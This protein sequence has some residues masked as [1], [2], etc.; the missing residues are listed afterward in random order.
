MKIQ[1]KILLLKSRAADQRACSAIIGAGSVYWRPIGTTDG[2]NRALEQETFQL[3]V[4]DHRNSGSDGTAA[5]ASLRKL[6]PQARVIL[7]SDALELNDVVQAMRM[8]VREVFP[9]PIDLPGVVKCVESSLE[10]DFGKPDPERWAV[11]LEFIGDDGVAVDQSSANSAPKRPKSPGGQKTASASGASP[12]GTDEAMAATRRA[13]ELAEQCA[14]LNEE[15][16]RLS[17]IEQRALALQREMDALRAE[18]VPAVQC[19]RDSQ[20]DAA[21]LEQARL[22]EA[23]AAQ[24]EERL[25]TEVAHVAGL[26]QRLSEHVARQESLQADLAETRR[27]LAANEKRLAELAHEREHGKKTDD[28]R[29]Q[30]TKEVAALTREKAN[31]LTELARIQEEEEQRSEQLEAVREQLAVAVAE[32]E[33]LRPLSERIQTLE[34]KIA[35][36][37]AE[38]EALEAE[39][40]AFAARDAE[41]ETLR[42]R[43]DAS[44]ARVL[45][46]TH[47]LQHTKAEAGKAVLA[48]EAK[49]TEAD[50]SLAA[51]RDAIR[52]RETALATA[53]A[54]HEQ[55]VAQIEEQLAQREANLAARDG[56]LAASVSRLESARSELER[57]VSE[58]EARESKLA[59]IET[60]ILADRSTLDAQVQDAASRLSEYTAKLAGLDD[61][62]TELDRTG[63]QL[64]SKAT[65]LEALRV[66]LEERAATLADER[67][68][69][70]K[71]RE[72]L[73]SERSRLDQATAALEAEKAALAKQHD[74]TTA[75]R[76]A[77][78]QRISW[79][80][81]KREEITGE[82]KR[83]LE[84]C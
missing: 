12:A 17:A 63:A 57:A 84:A 20:A 19:E 61:R 54:E 53:S 80:E 36:L 33:S 51:E 28:R 29:A 65:E 40:A 21:A 50:Q 67:S 5:I 38:R 27:T 9:P 58:H 30:A 8:G 24:L 47:D 56:E 39:T 32:L 73:A 81:Q 18:P 64:A 59:E 2:I 70:Q 42:A 22:A 34:T 41:R 69:L 68:S 10:A 83:F 45:E 49:A 16:A 3:V 62:A 14:R 46:L 79:F 72:T 74:A 26:E 44:E 6:Q 11:L 37:S 15:L 7:V 48:A 4:L 1:S 76:S 43:A 78:E 60:S 31:L 25:Q 75:E 13:N 23:R 71:I 82:M 55:T 35:E 52:S 66:D 77:L